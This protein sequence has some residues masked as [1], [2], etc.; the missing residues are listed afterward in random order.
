MPHNEN[1]KIRAKM[2]TFHFTFLSEFDVV[3]TPSTSFS[4][5]WHAFPMHSY[6]EKNYKLKTSPI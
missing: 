6:D 1:G 4:S 5:T 2:D 3:K